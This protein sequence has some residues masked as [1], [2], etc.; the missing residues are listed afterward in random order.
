MEKQDYV[1]AQGKQKAPYLFQVTQV[2]GKTISGVLE[3]DRRK[4]PTPIEISKKDVIVNLGPEPRSGKVYG[5]DVS[6]IYRK[7]FNHDWWGPIYFYVKPDAPTMK[8][9][10]T[11][12]DRT[13]EVLEKKKLTDFVE[14]FSTE[15]R[16][17]QGKY[18]GMYHHNPKQGSTVWYAPECSQG[19]QTTM[20]YVIF[21]EFGH[22][23]R[24]NGL[25]AAVKLRQKWLR[26]YQKSIKPIVVPAKALSSVHDQLIE[27]R[28][29]DDGIGFTEAMRN[30]ASVDEKHAKVVKVLNEW[31]KKIHH[32]GA[33]ELGLAWQAD[34][35]SY[36]NKLWPTAPIDT[37]DLN[38]I[39]SE[40]AT[41]NVEEL[42]AETFAFYM[43]KTKLPDEY[44][45][46]MEESLSWARTAVKNTP[47][48]E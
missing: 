19:S 29:S 4:K 5:I 18:A 1:I 45:E 24:Y 15:I 32:V 39:I 28:Q 17:K 21:H 38:P 35:L 11:G 20:N 12:L 42:F 40:Y 8:V 43:Q 46:L 2:D 7:A 41:R 36:I 25:S 44:V 30:V 48:G 26:L 34:D 3:Q 6:N 33:K 22:A 37:S 16:A 31:F 9:L 14:L 13:A 23:V 10:R 47:D 27:Q